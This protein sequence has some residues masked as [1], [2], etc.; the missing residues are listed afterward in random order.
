MAVDLLANHRTVPDCH[1]RG[2]VWL[3]P[4]PVAPG[5]LQAIQLAWFAAGVSGDLHAGDRHFARQSAGLVRVEPDL[6]I[7]RGW[8]AVAGAV[9]DQ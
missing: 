1:G 8:V 7:T 3:A 2:G 5:A 9:P 4:G 6:R